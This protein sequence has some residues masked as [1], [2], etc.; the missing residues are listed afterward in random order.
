MQAAVALGERCSQLALV[1]GQ[2]VLNDEGAEA[3]SPTYLPVARMFWV[4]A[5]NSH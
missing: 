5:A 4:F 1:R 2:H 3:D